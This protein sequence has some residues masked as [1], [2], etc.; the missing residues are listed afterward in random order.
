MAG[1]QLY[2]TN[3][4]KSC[5]KKRNEK[6]GESGSF[7]NTELDDDQTLDDRAPPYMQT[8]NRV[9]ESGNYVWLIVACFL[10]V[11]IA[12][13]STWMRFGHLHTMQGNETVGSVASDGGTNPFA[14]TPRDLV[15]PQTEA[16]TRASEDLKSSETQEFG[17][18]FIM[19]AVVFVVT[20][21]VGIGTGYK[22]GFAGVYSR[23]KIKGVWSGAYETTSGFTSYD[24][25]CHYYKPRIQIAQARLKTLQHN[26][27]QQQAD[28]SLPLNKK[29]IDFMMLDE[30]GS[31]NSASI[32]AKTTVQET[33]AQASNH[34]QVQHHV[35]APIQPVQSAVAPEAS[36]QPKSKFCSD[37]G[38]GITA[39]SKFCG[40]CGLSLA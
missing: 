14:N 39:N 33:T 2:R 35:E 19:L 28:H 3:L 18:A 24:G 26:L 27:A 10:I 8:L 1:H 25:M 32:P 15:A 30:N 38:T 34:S 16:N 31:E 37:C 4:I 6:R 29:F 13:G 17:A 12:I 36:S 22:Y 20:Q 7:K 23:K 11:A 9:G 5:I 21:I 40:G